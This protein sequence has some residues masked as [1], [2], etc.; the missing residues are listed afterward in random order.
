MAE[1]KILTIAEL[2]AR[3]GKMTQKEL[4]KELNVTQ[5]AVSN[6]E[7]DQLEINGRRLIAIANF[8]KVSIDDLLGISV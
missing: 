4:A 1:K 2:R 7:K 8:F 3:H 5:S 6:W